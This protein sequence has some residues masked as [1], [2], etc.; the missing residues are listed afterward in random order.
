MVTLGIDRLLQYRRLR[1]RGQRAGLVAN[2][3]SQT[4]TLMPTIDALQAH[5][6]IRLSALFGPEHGVRGEA[7]AGEP[8]AAARDPAT[9]LP[10]H[11]LYGATTRPTPEMLNGLDVIFID[12][13]DAGV[14]FF[15]YVYT[16]SYVM[17]AAAAQGIGVVVLDRPNPIT[18]GRVEGNVL[19]PAFRSFVGRYP[20][21][22]RHGMTMGELAGW[23]N[24]VCGIGC[25]LD[26]VAMRGW[27]RSQWYDQTGCFW[28][29]PGPNVPT[30][31][32]LTVYPGTCLV[33]GTNVSEGRGTT[34]S[35]EVI[36]APWI[37][38]RRL[39]QRLRAQELPGVAF[40]QACF[41][42]TFSKYAGDVCAGVQLHVTCR[43]RFL[44]VL[45]GLAL[46]EAIRDLF[47]ESFRW[48][49]EKPREPCFFDLLMGTDQIRKQLEA[50]HSAAT[51]CRGFDAGL[52]AFNRQRARFLRY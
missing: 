7:Q 20:M 4:A 40:R 43:D 46:I 45:T 25:R 41:R 39:W 6:G 23:I 26:V 21:A 36:G 42:P 38:A 48:R 27:R 11:S 32:T 13:Q 10:V 18:G 51:I 19:D 37:D 31:D 15:T 50:G 22:L 34:R 2:Q 47:P 3:T 5:P 49:R 52:E 24:N 9:G 12:L 35:F 30:L 29:Q 16:L 44:P 33:E 8:V 28:V 1:W 17:E 14:R